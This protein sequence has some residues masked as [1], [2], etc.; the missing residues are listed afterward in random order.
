[1]AEV[2]LARL[3]GPSG[4]QKMLVVKKLLPHL[5]SD[6][7]MVDMFVAEA[8]LAARVQHKNIV[9][10][11]EFDRIE[12]GEYILAMEY[13]Q[14]TD[15]RHVLAL[16]ERK[17]LRIPPWFS[18]YVMTEV[19]E[20]L[21]FAHELTDENGTPHQIVHRD[22]T[23]SNIFISLTGEVK[24]GDFGVARDMT[25]PSTTRHGEVKGKLTY[26]SP[27]Q[28]R[29]KEVDQR[30]DLFSAGV[31]LWECLSQRRLFKAESEL[32]T[33]L[34]ITQGTR[35]P[36]SDHV[37]DVPEAL[38]Q[39]VLE[40][41]ATLPDDRAPTAREM[42]F[43][44]R[45]VLRA[46]RPRLAPQD[47]AGFM[48]SLA[49]GSTEVLPLRAVRVR[50]GVTRSMQAFDTSSGAS[51]RA[52]ADE[53]VD[54]LQSDDLIVVEARLSSIP[55]PGPSE[56][57]AIPEVLTQPPLATP[58][59]VAPEARPL[60]EAAL[61][62]AAGAEVSESSIQN[63]V[64]QSRRGSGRVVLAALAI[65]ASISVAVWLG[66]RTRELE[67]A[68]PRPS[69][70][71]V[72]APARAE[73]E[74]DRAERPSTVETDLTDVAAPPP[75]P[76]RAEALPPAPPPPERSAPDPATAKRPIERSPKRSLAA[77]APTPAPPPR[78]TEPAAAPAG[79]TLEPARARA[80]AAEGLSLPPLPAPETEAPAPPAA[81]ASEARSPEPAPSPKPAPK[82]AAPAPS[83]AITR[84]S[85]PPTDQAF[86]DLTSARCGKC[87]PAAQVFEA[88]RAGKTP[89]TGRVFE[90]D[91]IKQQVI[92]C[93]RLPHSNIS[94][95]DAREILG[96]LVRTRERAKRPR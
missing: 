4:F 20:G 90:S 73:R 42:L 32:D 83:G 7:R 28:A 57:I 95:D 81:A 88:L 75:T 14:G 40:A 72:S 87:H 33:M 11:F 67:P 94:K 60:P 50:A 48:R 51:A 24:L 35:V 46:L 15:L 44:L 3:P 64:L 31:V 39:V 21:A 76:A 91:Q 70:A 92:R 62:A 71:G 96:F 52:P 36:P 12:S 34:A 93:T 8:T 17:G 26:M 59:T 85:I 77:R 80:R 9:Q 43:R 53:E 18:V 56:T 89:I 2:F 30:S 38:D 6:P 29:G 84:A 82:P 61:R 66:L 55:P 49:Q 5:S 69:S 41:L 47:V 45:E 79:A 37:T 16:G 22:L 68:P 23:P 27:E 13:V 10:V 86:F 19:L 1:M 65:G 63:L 25:L 74:V 78:S 58:K 54:T